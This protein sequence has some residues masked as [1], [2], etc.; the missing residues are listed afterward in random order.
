MLEL[1]TVNFNKVFIG[2][3]IITCLELGTLKE[4]ILIKLL[5]VDLS[6]FGRR[7]DE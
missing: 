4:V 6:K 3:F 5:Y 7:F 2:Y 1:F